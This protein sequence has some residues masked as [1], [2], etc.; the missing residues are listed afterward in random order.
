MIKHE[1]YITLQCIA[2]ER[3]DR[4]LRELIRGP[5]GHL[6]RRLYRPLELSY[7]CIMESSEKRACRVW[8]HHTYVCTRSCILW[9][10]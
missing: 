1:K 2:A 4:G 5:T 7:F 10:I 8:I 9:Y 3:E 6:F